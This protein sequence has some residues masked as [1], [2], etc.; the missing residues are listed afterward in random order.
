MEIKNSVVLLAVLYVAEISAAAARRVSPV[1][2]KLRV[3]T[4]ERAG[5]YRKCKL[6]GQIAV[7]PHCLVHAYIVSGSEASGERL[8]GGDMPGWWLR[9]W[10]HVVG[11]LSD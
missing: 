11:G 9:C 3:P 7:A 10:G 6:I 2:P 5:R 4:L 1:W 8:R